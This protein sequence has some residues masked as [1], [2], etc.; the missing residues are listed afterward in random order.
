VGDLRSEQWTLQAPDG[1]EI[2]VYE[3]LPDADPIGVVQIAHG[4]VEHGLRYQRFAEALTKEG[5]AVFANDHRGHGKTAKS[6][7]ERGHFADQNGWDIAIGDMKQLNDVIRSRFPKLP[8]ILFGH[9][10]GSFLSRRYAQLYGNSISALILSGTGGDPG[11]LGSLGLL[12]AKREIRKKGKRA[13]SDLMNKLIFGRYNKAFRPART[14]FDWL[15]RDPSEVDQYIQDPDCGFLAST[16][17][18]A[19]LIK[20][21]KELDRPEWL[22]RMPKDLPVLFISGDQDPVGAN[23][24]G[25]KQ[26]YRNFK[27]VGM[28]DVTCK[29]YEGGRHELLNETNRMEVMR[30]IVQWID[31]HINKTLS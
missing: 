11:F 2:H 14:P 30:D 13:K 15:S 25:V 1:V 9:S 16:T 5:I 12:V 18:Y 24:R 29:L 20:G 8:I 7:E 10:L 23:G 26:V 21:L 28:T 6:G 27:K 31:E 17:F 4:M 19:D 22:N 3:W